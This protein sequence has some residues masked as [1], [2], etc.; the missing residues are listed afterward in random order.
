MSFGILQHAVWEKN[1]RLAPLLIPRDG[2]F[3]VPPGLDDSNSSS[4]D[5]AFKNEDPL[6]T[7][8]AINL[9][10]QDSDA[11]VRVGAPQNLD[12]LFELWELLA[13]GLNVVPMSPAEYGF[14]GNVTISEGGGLFAARPEYERF[15]IRSSGED[16]LGTALL[17]L[18]EA[19]P[20]H[21]FGLSQSGFEEGDLQF[22][23]A[24]VQV[25]T[26]DEGDQYDLLVVPAISMPRETMSGALEVLRTRCRRLNSIA[27]CVKWNRDYT[28]AFPELI[29][30]ER[31]AYSATFGDIVG[32]LDSFGYSETETQFGF[33][34]ASVT[35][36]K[37][38]LLV[39][40]IAV[41][42]IQVYLFAAIRMAV[43]ATNGVYGEYPV[44]AV[45]WIALFSAGVPLFVWR[46][47]LT[48]P[49]LCILGVV[50]RSLIDPGGSAESSGL[51]V[52][53]FLLIVSIL[54]ALLTWCSALRLRVAAG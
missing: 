45:P 43:Q 54:L 3:C 5:V 50:I 40:T 29:G 25:L 44:P 51:I 37:E 33:L 16:A 32:V 8:N 4:A 31:V 2:P 38:A 10:V 42:V 9:T 39:I 22:T 7:R 1:D 14:I 46:F 12:E 6:S 17:C 47:S 15:E 36:R 30:T 27:S 19:D 49:A 52:T 53:S 13:E 21:F 26:H 34:G 24:Y 18:I 28:E 35:T 11:H 48:I 20:E 23:H 41:I